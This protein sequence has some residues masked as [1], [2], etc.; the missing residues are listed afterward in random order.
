VC[1]HE[2]LFPTGRRVR[3]LL[4]EG[5]KPHI[6]SI[7]EYRELYQ[8]SINA[9]E[10][11]WAAAAREMLSWHTDFATT[12]SGSLAEG[13]VKWFE[14]GKLNV[15][16]N[17]V[18][19]HA[20]AHPE[21][22]AL[23]WEGDE[24]GQ[25]RRITY[26]ELLIEVERVACHLRSLSELS[27]APVVTIYMPM[28]PETVFAMLACA[29]LGLPHNVVFAGFSAESL[30]DR[31]ADA[32]SRVLFTADFGHRG[33]KRIPLLKIAKEA[34]NMHRSK[35][36]DY[37]GV[38][39]VI[40][41]ERDEV[42]ANGVLANGV[43]ANGALAN[44]VLANGDSGKED[45]GDAATEG[46]AVYASW[47]ETIGRIAVD[48]ETIAEPEAFPSE[49][50][51]FLLYTSGSTGKPKGLLHTSAGYLLYAAWTARHSFDLHPEIGDVFGC[52]ADVGWITGHS[53]I[54]YGPLALGA[55]SVLFESIPTYPNASRY[56]ELVDRLAITQ[57][58]TAPTVI[59]ALRRLGDAPVAPFSL[60]TLRVLGSV[61]EPINADA[62]LWYR[63]VVGKDECSVVDTFWQTETG[64]HVIAPLPAVHDVKP[65]AAGFP[66]LGID[67]QLL[68][69][70]TGAVLGG[71]G[72]E[73]V[74]CIGQPWPGMARSVFGDH[75]RY[76]NTYL[77]PYPGF[78]FTGDAAARDADAHLWIRGRVDDVINVSGHRL[79]TAE[80]EA[81][82]GRH[83]RCAEAAVLGRPDELTGQAIWAFCILKP[84]E[85]AADAPD[86]KI[87]AEMVQLVRS[88]IGPI[89][90]PQAILLTS[91]LPKTRSGKIM[92][93]LLRKI[94]AGEADQLG[95]LSTLNNPAII[96]EVKMLVEQELS[97]RKQPNQ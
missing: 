73:G 96:E 6:G 75:E 21:R 78:Y 17:C 66:C 61:G 60:Q 67:A 86:A 37:K 18:D 74:L 20:R 12:L 94:L 38:S 31:L 1:R 57:L 24:P 89:A 92:R 32:R 70:A 97:N 11:F 62:W 27:T 29:R 95:D 40:V 28:V 2:R 82:L 58:Y 46:A 47:K 7:E 48:F 16:W 52:L 35:D 90:T 34:L 72:V 87:R 5:V 50:P 3:E 68:D 41:L 44:G 8:R 39:Q 25:S 93:R 71:A 91:D 81:A 54:V 15:A 84:G 23:I 19:R 42:L 63:H 65:G 77:R 10:T 9:P 43:H 64:G 30:H 76:M 56:W 88:A 53:Y 14:E 13:N 83:A 51:L 45:P 85:G 26:R 79:S 36:S 80:I 33:G 49:H 59:R 55:T 4:P 69:P 22:L